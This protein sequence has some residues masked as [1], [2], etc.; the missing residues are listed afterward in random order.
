M[1]TVERRLRAAVAGGRAANFRDLKERPIVQAT[2]VRELV[3]GGAAPSGVEIAYATIVGGLDLVHARSAGGGDCHAL[4]LRDSVLMGP[5]T[6]SSGSEVSPDN[7]RADGEDVLGLDARHSQLSLLSLTNCRVEGIDLT[8]AAIAG[9]LILDG[10]RP[11]PRGRSCW[12]RARGLRV[13]GAVTL[14]R[15][16]LC[17]PERLPEYWGSGGPYALDL[18]GAQVAGAL[19]LLERFVARGGVNLARTTVGGAVSVYGGTQLIAAG[20][21]DGNGDVAMR[22]AYA[23]LQGQLFLIGGRSAADRFR[24]KGTLDFYGCHIGGSMSLQGVGLTRAD[25]GRPL[26]ASLD[27]TSATVSRGLFLCSY[28]NT[29][30]E[31]ADPVVL[32]GAVIGGSVAIDASSVAPVKSVDATTL[33]ISGDLTLSGSVESTTLSGS[34]VGGNIELSGVPASPINTVDATGVKVQGTLRLTGPMAGT[35]DFSGSLIEG[36]VEL[37]IEKSPFALDATSTSELPGLKLVGTSVGGALSVASGMTALP[38]AT[39]KP[40]FRTA[41]LLCYRGWRLAEA[42]TSSWDETEMPILSFL[43]RPHRRANIYR[44]LRKGNV[45]ILNGESDPIHEFNQPGALHVLLGFGRR[46]PTLEKE[47]QVKQ[48]LSL[49]CNYIW[50]REGA[51]AVDHGAVRVRPAATDD[52][53][54][55][56]VREDL[57]RAPEHGSWQAVGIVDYASERFESTFLIEPSGLVWMLADERLGKVAE[58]PV[59]RYDAPLRW[60]SVSSARK[61]PDWPTPPPL[62]F[63]F[64]SK[65]DRLHWNDVQRELLLDLKEQFGP[66]LE[67]QRR[68]SIDLRGLKASLL[69][70]GEGKNWGLGDDHWPYAGPKLLLRLSGFEYGRIDSRSPEAPPSEDG[71]IAPSLSPEEFNTAG[72]SDRI[73]RL[74]PEV[75][76]GQKE[77][78][79]YRRNWLKAQYKVA[80]PTEDDYRPQPYQHLAAVWRT[81]GHFD[82]ADKIAYDKLTLEKVRLRARARS[83]Y[84]KETP[85]VFTKWLVGR[86][87]HSVKWR[88]GRIWQWLKWFAVRIRHS[89][90]QRLW[91]L[92]VQLPFGFGLRPGRAALVFVSFWAAGVIAVVA[93]SELLT[94]DASAVATVVA[95]QEGRDTV[96]VEPLIEP[97]SEIEEAA[98]PPEPR[99]EIECG[100]HISRIIYPLDVMIPLIDLR[101]ESRCQFSLD[102]RAW[103]VAKGFYAIVG[104]LVTSGLIVTLSGVVRRRIEA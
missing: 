45:V 1:T 95:R 22:A 5:A 55:E 11:L 17:L 101:Q 49:F 65:S 38:R 80:P 96:V 27:L 60:V 53:F 26:E 70:D 88:V 12:I 36:D 34:I 93:L 40:R 44:R 15:A 28:D 43:Y 66:S 46:K 86:V 52:A 62:G 18:D 73:G 32:R 99:R 56:A 87:W 25:P 78:L 35:C 67:T 68:A 31:A 9:D 6:S 3:L 92:F 41:E 10:L 7:G 33:R 100:D 58:R 89:V 104:W 2:W 37:G 85:R 69:S 77:L 47:Q 102:A 19:S 97:Q 63:E 75:A 48:Y 64:S 21:G 72:Q 84:E 14:S 94:L 16:R 13:G 30:F 50:G 71:S 74:D 57:G 42:T 79:A 29:P 82:L 51:F 83:R 76:I 4:I 20:R 81:A 23:Q 8:S 54:V 61:I 24:A 91:R 90:K 39:T 59:V 103:G 98:P